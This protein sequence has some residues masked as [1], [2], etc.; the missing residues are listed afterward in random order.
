MRN[1]KNIP[2]EADEYI[3]HKYMNAVRQN[4]QIDSDPSK[5]LTTSFLVA[6]KWDAQR[7]QDA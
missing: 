6:L 4:L 2:L 1:K 3:K 5:V 7:E